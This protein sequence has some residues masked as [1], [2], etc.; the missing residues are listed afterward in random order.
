MKNYRIIN[1]L[2]E[3]KAHI[4]AISSKEALYVHNKNYK[5]AK[6]GDY[7]AILEEHLNTFKKNIKK[8]N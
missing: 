3:T 1:V 2:G 8:L 4:K 6:E 5:T 7:F